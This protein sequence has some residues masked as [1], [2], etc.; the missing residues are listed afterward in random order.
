MGKCSHSAE[1][2]TAREGETQDTGCDVFIGRRRTKRG[3]NNTE[4]ATEGVKREIS[5]L[6]DKIAMTETPLQQKEEEKTKQE[7]PMPKRQTIADIRAKSN[8]GKGDGEYLAIKRRPNR[9]LGAHRGGSAAKTL[10]YRRKTIQL[11][12]SSKWRRTARRAN[13]GNT[14]HSM[15]RSSE[16]KAR[17]EQE[18]EEKIRAKQQLQQNESKRNTV[19]RKINITARPGNLTPSVRMTLHQ[20]KQEKKTPS[21]GY[22]NP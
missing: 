9:T 16:E 13:G 7:K 17:D 1:K 10:G 14:T 15:Y 8:R 6:E 19:C 18:K 22:V 21:A 11:Q 4:H 2:T 3:K 20:R 5:Q 12:L